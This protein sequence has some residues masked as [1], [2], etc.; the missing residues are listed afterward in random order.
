METNAANVKCNSHGTSMYFLG[1]LSC[2]AF[3]WQCREV[4]RRDGSKEIRWWTAVRCTS[5]SCSLGCP[6]S[7]RAAGDGRWPMAMGGQQNQF[8]AIEVYE[9]NHYIITFLSFARNRIGAVFVKDQRPQPASFAQ[10][11]SIP[12]SLLPDLTPKVS[13]RTNHDVFLYPLC[14]NADVYLLGQS[15]NCCISTST[16]TF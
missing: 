14:R 1:R 9:Y 15:I 7:R 13:S 4:H 16:V 8:T 3:G 12:L 10:I 2:D 5:R 11:S 6:V